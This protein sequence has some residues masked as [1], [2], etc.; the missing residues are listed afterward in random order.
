[1]KRCGEHSKTSISGMDTDAQRL[2]LQA[3]STSEWIWSIYLKFGVF[4]IGSMIVTPVA[5]VLFNW[6]V[7]GS[8]IVDHF[9]RMIKTT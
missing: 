2:L 4:L 1:M 9:Y 7:D 5:S 3:N 6:F 8:L